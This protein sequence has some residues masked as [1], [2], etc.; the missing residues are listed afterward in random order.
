MYKGTDLSLIML[1]VFIP[2]AAASCIML[3]PTPLLEPFCMTQSPA[4][5]RHWRSVYS[6][7]IITLEVVALSLHYKLLVISLPGFKVTNAFSILYAV[8]GFTINVAPRSTGIS[9]DI[10]INFLAWATI[11]VLQVPGNKVK[12]VTHHHTK[13][14]KF[15]AH[16]DFLFLDWSGPSI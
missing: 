4:W 12:A 7:I 6:Y 14:L 5:W 1:I 10:L 13:Y 2:Q 16:I 3:C 11:T 15:R 9:L 8:W